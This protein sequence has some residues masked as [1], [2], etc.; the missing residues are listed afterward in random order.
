MKE[1]QVF[2]N[3]SPGWSFIVCCVGCGCSLTVSLFLKICC[4]RSNIA[5]TEIPYIS[6]TVHDEA[7]DNGRRPFS[8]SSPFIPPSTERPNLR[9]YGSSRSESE[10]SSQTT[11]ILTRYHTRHSSDASSTNSLQVSNPS[12]SSNS[13]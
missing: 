5:P 6:Q 7:T 1:I 10:F 11:N 13:Y 4:T 12:D 2:P 3:S 9:S 8:S